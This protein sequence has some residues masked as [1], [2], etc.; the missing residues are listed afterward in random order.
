M[1]MYAIRGSDGTFY[2][3]LGSAPTNN[4]IFIEWFAYRAP[5]QNIIDNQENQ[6]KMLP[7]NPKVVKFQLVEIPL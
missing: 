6:N 2:A 4:P 5:T 7:P 1:E 3:M